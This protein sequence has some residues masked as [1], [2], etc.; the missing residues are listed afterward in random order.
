MIGGPHKSETAFTIHR[1][2]KQL[3]VGK[4]RPNDIGPRVVAGAE[5]PAGKQTR[6]YV[7]YG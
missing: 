5:I 7:I 4:V 3:V 1:H 6:L 2:V